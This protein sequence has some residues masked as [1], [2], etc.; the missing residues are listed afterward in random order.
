MAKINT[1]STIKHAVSGNEYLG[2]SPADCL[3]GA[4]AMHDEIIEQDSRLWV[5]ADKVRSELL[6]LQEKHGLSVAALSSGNALSL[7]ELLC[8]LM[9]DCHDKYQLRDCL[10]ALQVHFGTETGKIAA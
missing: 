7:V 8:D 1:I 6:S 5:L 4:K 9:N 10:E 2:I 3:A